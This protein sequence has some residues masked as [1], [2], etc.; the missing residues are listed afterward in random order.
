[1]LFITCF[2]GNIVVRRN[3]I[4]GWIFLMLFAALMAGFVQGVTGFGSGIIMMIF[5]PY[6]LPINQSAGVSTLTMIVAN[7]MVVWH[8]RKYLK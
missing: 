2:K 6:L 8:Y 4:L 7:I 3:D 5:L 1:M